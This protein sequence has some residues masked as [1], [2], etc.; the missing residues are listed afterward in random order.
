MRMRFKFNMVEIALAIAVIAIGLSAILV[1]FPIGINATRSAMD[2]NQYLEAAEYI[3]NLIRGKFEEQWR[4]QAESG[5]FAKIDLSNIKIGDKNLVANNGY[6]RLSKGQANNVNDVG[7]IRELERIEENKATWNDV[8]DIPEMSYNSAGI[9]KYTRKDQEG[10]EVFSAVVRIWSEGDDP[11]AST[12]TSRSACPL[13]VPSA[14]D[15][16]T[17]P[18]VPVEDGTKIQYLD[19][20]STPP[21]RSL[22]ENIFKQYGQSVMVEISWGDNYRTFRVDLYNPYFRIAP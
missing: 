3:S 2:D 18:L 13:R 7:T 6:P 14:N 11:L 8:T 21:Q 1:L 12:N 22:Y 17:D 20:N 9:F 16:E 4:A 5:V 15:R 10:S 19:L